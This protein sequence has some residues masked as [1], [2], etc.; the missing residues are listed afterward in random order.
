[1]ENEPPGRGGFL[2]YCNAAVSA[3]DPGPPSS[4][5][6][7]SVAK[8]GNVLRSGPSVQSLINLLLQA[9]AVHLSGSESQHRRG[10]SPTAAWWRRHVSIRT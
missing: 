3:E 7:V 9:A 5:G 1:M 8:D 10:W 2:P 6:W 4:L